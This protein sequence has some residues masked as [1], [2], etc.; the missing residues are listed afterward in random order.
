MVKLSI[1]TPVFNEEKN[2][3][4]LYRQ[5]F[6]VLKNDFKELEY[7]IIF[8]NDGSKDGT[9]SLLKELN[10]FDPN[11]KVISLSRNFGHYGA[12]TAALDH[13]TG[14]VIVTMDGDLQDKPDQIPLLY[15]TLMEGNDI[16]YAIR[17][18][19]QDNFFKK[20]TSHLFWW[21]ITK[22]SSVPITPNQGMFR[23]FNKKVLAVINTLRE[24]DRFLPGLFAWI[25]FKQGTA[26]VE[27]GKRFQGE[28]KYNLIK[29]FSLSLNAMIGFSTAI[30]SWISFTGL[31]VA[32]I[33]FL[34]GA[35]IIIFK[36]FYN[37][38]ILGWSSLASLISFLCGLILFAVGILG[39]YIGKLYR[40]AL[41]RPLYIVDEKIGWGQPQVF[42]SDY[43]RSIYAVDEK[44]GF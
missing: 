28:T 7:E 17:K 36:L 41:A 24:G 9:L 35:K 18:N 39:I 12:T 26:E 30:L 43:R 33:S 27:H 13:A 5:L 20:L 31:F 38:G 6:A 29:L 15:K 3:N 44:I 2:I 8:V 14:D 25:G 40:H 16:V 32:G 23:I 1:L 37:H 22:V 21:A 11:V 42:H 34:F 10:A 4:E 19:R